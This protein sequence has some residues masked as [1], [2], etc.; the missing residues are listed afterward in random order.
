MEYVKIGRKI[1]IDI[2]N[3]KYVMITSRRKVM[4]KTKYKNVR[5]EKF[6]MDK[7]TIP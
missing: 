3:E 7:K 4:R 2:V 6:L 5:I 1:S